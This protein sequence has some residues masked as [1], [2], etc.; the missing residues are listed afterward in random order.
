MRRFLPGIVVGV[1]LIYLA[2]TVLRPIPSPAGF[3]IADFG[4][5]PV[6]MSGRVLPI[7]SV[8]R[9]G[10]LQV[11]GSATVPLD[12]GSAW[13]WGREMDA[14]EW[15]L[16][17]MAKPGSADARR[18]FR[19]DDATV[20][21]TLHLPPSISG[22][23][24]FSDLA[25]RL[26]EVGKQA[27]RI[28]KIESS[29]RAAWERELLKLRNRLLVYERLK[30]SLQ[31]NSF[32]AKQAGGR[33]VAYDFAARLG[34][35]QSS[36]RAGVEAAVAREHRKAQE[37]DKETEDAM[38]RFAQPYIGVSRVAVVAIVPP[39]DLARSRD[40]WENIGTA[41][42]NSARTG[43]LSEA[44][45]HFAAMSSAFAQGKPDVFNREMATYRNYL[46]AK[47]LSSEVSTGR[48]EFFYN[49]FQPYVRAAAM[50]LLAS[51]LL[52]AYWLK[53]STALYR[54]VAVLVVA[55]CALHMAGLL[56]ELMIEG[57][58]PITNVFASVM[59]G[60]WSVVLIC[61][62][63]ERRWRNAIGLSLAA[64]SG[65]AAVALAHGLAPNGT[66]VLIGSILDAPFWIAAALLAIAFGL[67]RPSKI[68]PV[69]ST[70]QLAA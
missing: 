5:L 58:P 65:L 11:R 50:Y 31:P 63:I 17:L 59:L 21:R 60:G 30:N 16:E 66:S 24:A 41:V 1:S 23:Y 53:R 62:G 44:V 46:D 10:L 29:K 15:L 70:A 7:D 19:V 28:G 6:Y 12:G 4:R 52:I 61:G 54:S 47:G 51:L 45:S 69:D 57:R 43:K 27:A 36:L 49:R 64:V 3:N 9:I 32:L 68:E 42:V 38:R 2:A 22:Y 13:T 67:G 40:H 55:A 33:A 14:T 56:F 18:I 37:L 26:D 35:Y 39:A 34:E 20:L 25:P 48:Y 8:A